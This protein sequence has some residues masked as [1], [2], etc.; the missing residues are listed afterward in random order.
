MQY[1]NYILLLMIIL[2]TPIIAHSIKKKHYKKIPAYSYDIKRKDIKLYKSKGKVVTIKKSYRKTKIRNKRY[3]IPRIIRKTH[4]VQLFGGYGPKNSLQV[5][6]NQI[7]IEK[8]AVIGVGY[9]Y[10]FQGPFEIGGIVFTNGMIGGT[11]TFGF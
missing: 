2:N 7:V 6:S 10:S 1:V 11:L 8:N 3:Y 4:R 9:S 5:Q